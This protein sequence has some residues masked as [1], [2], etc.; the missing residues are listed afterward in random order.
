MGGKL[1]KMAKL[2][3]GFVFFTYFPGSVRTMVLEI[4]SQYNGFGNV[5]A[6]QWAYSGRISLETYDTT[7]NELG[8]VLAEK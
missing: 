3:D 5:L 6:E 8:I 1:T 7:M 2:L 4:I